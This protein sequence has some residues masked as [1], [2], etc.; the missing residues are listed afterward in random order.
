MS[1]SSC[2]SG[3]IQLPAAPNPDLFVQ[4]GKRTTSPSAHRKQCTLCHTPCDV[5]VRCRIDE[6]LGWHFVCPYKCWTQVPGGEIDG[7]GKPYYQYGGMWKNKHVGVSAKKPKR[8]GKA[9]RT[10]K[11]WAASGEYVTN[12][13]VRH[14]GEMW[15]C[16]RSHV[17]REETTPGYAYRYWKESGDGVDLHEGDEP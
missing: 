2:S 5:L 15:V 13:R 14:E 6:T 4:N 12:N 10:A 7:P 16:R 8:K 11:T 9:N 3:R 17:S 1:H